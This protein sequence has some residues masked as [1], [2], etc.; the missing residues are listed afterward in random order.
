[1]GYLCGTVFIATIPVVI[2]WRSGGHRWGGLFSRVAA[3]LAVVGLL[4]WLQRGA[5]LSPWTDPLAALVFLGA[6]LAM[7]R[8]DLGLLPLR[9]PGRRA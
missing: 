2:T 1:L 6:W 8:T 4:V 5:G 3:G 9:R 7:S